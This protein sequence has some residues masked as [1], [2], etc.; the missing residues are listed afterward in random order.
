MDSIF[1][2]DAYSN[3]KEGKGMN[4]EIRFRAWLKKEKI[5]CA[6]LELINNGRVGIDIQDSGPFIKRSEEIEL[7]QY[8]GLK[9]KNG[10]EIYENDLVKITSFKSQVQEI[11]LIGVV[12][13]SNF[14]AYKVEN[15]KKI[16]W[17]YFGK[18]VE[19]NEFIYFLNL[20][21]R[22]IE[23]IGTIYENPE[24]LKS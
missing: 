2:L 1:A 7:M 22:D 5:M 17:K 11:E 19:P 23:I 8:T 6:V 10:K 3:I 20:G 24:L 12:A 14:G 4:R 21:G 9:D 13:Y 18:D 16:K 15:I